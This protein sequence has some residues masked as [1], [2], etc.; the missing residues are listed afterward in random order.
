MK[1]GAAASISLF[2]VV[3]ALAGCAAFDVPGHEPEC[4]VPIGQ[5]SR[6]VGEATAEGLQAR[7]WNGPLRVVGTARH[8]D[9]LAIRQV[10]VAG[11]P[12]T[13]REGAF[14]FSWW[15]AEISYEVLESLRAA[16]S[17][18]IALQITATDAC[19]FTH[20]VYSVPFVLEDQ[21]EV[22]VDA[23][24]LELVLPPGRDYLPVTQSAPAS[25]QVSASAQAV[26]AE[27]VL[28]AT[29][30]S[31][32]PS[33]SG[34]ITL[35]LS[36]SPSGRATASALFYGDRPGTVL[37]T[38]SAQSVV[39]TATVT[40][41]GPPVLAPSGGDLRA[42]ESI[43][44]E[45]LTEGGLRSLGPCLASPVS[46]VDVRSSG[47]LMAGGAV[48]DTNGDGR[49]DFT[50]SVDA[51]LEQNVSVLVTCVDDYGQSTSAT[52]RALAL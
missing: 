21:V 38:A 8:R 30:G 25:V 28:R 2:A 27:V 6:I 17:R 47:D 33:D 29:S 4:V 7:A 14:N 12:A 37:V 16:G 46:G 23:L 15:E 43:R 22:I 5:E 13:L 1:T 3:C 19:A 44:V 10:Y 39:A 49:P 26:G 45:I 24:E 11:V 51:D 18:D 40:V 34:E 41:A 36:A 48:V 35:T 52:F 20:R 42:G 50:V 32:S 31:F 9:D